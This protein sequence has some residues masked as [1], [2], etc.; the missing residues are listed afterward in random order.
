MA[1]D[2]SCLFCKI[3]TGEI[4]NHTVYEN[5]D[6]LAFLDIHPLSKG[7]TLLI[8][9]KHVRWV[10]DVEPF[11]TYWETARDI[12]T[13]LDKALEPEWVQYFTHGV[14]PHAHIHILPRYDDVQSA[15]TLPD[16]QYSADADNLEKLAGRI[17]SFAQ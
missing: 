3:A 7:H 16:D 13:A 4:P 5:S 11:G 1:H 6:F 9:K 17:R 15:K 2:Q 12:K 8:P 14:I 10:H